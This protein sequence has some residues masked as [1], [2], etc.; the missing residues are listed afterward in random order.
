[1]SITNNLSRDNRRVYESTMDEHTKLIFY[2]E[3]VKYVSI[4][5]LQYKFKNFASYDSIAHLIEFAKKHP[6]EEI[7]C[8]PNYEE[9]LY[10]IGGGICDSLASYEYE[11]FTPIMGIDAFLQIKKLFFEESASYGKHR[12]E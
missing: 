12:R 3:L 5:E 11:E 2:Y 9:I 7:L 8:N 10:I 4:N 6:F 1:M